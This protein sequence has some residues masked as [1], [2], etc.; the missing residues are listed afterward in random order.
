[1][2]PH[3]IYFIVGCRYHSIVVRRF[4]RILPHDPPVDRDG[5]AV[6]QPTFYCPRCGVQIGPIGTH[7]DAKSDCVACTLTTAQAPKFQSAEIWVKIAVHV[8]GIAALFGTPSVATLLAFLG[9]QLGL[10]R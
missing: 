3:G 4:L 9:D 7:V 5:L 8:A 6:K 2:Q 1:V 10:S